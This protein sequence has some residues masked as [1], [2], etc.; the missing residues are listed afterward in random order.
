MFFSCSINISSLVLTFK[1]TKISLLFLMLFV[2]YY[3]YIY[4]L[5]IFISLSL[6]FFIFFASILFFR[7]F[8]EFFTL[9]Y[10]HCIFVINCRNCFFSSF[11]EKTKNK[12]SRYQKIGFEYSYF[13]IWVSL[14]SFFK[15]IYC[16]L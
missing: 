8:F 6:I 14:S 16:I 2:C 4:S 3:G 9:S 10:H 12:P 5:L 13:L 15:K 11:F 7:T 1:N